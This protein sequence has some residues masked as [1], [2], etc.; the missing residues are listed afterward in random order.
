MA[1]LSDDLLTLNGKLDDN[2]V[3]I[4]TKLDKLLTTS[5]VSI[6]LFV[7]NRVLTWTAIFDC[8]SGCFGRSGKQ[9]E[10]SNLNIC[11]LGNVRLEINL[12]FVIV[13]Y[14]ILHR[15]DFDFMWNAHGIQCPWQWHQEY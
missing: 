1:K 6:H 4:N 7:P 5:L 11:I 15:T 3:T 8:S 13:L 12:V 14:V 9:F 2:M 10:W